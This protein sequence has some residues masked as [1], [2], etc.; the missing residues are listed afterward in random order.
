M[1]ARLDPTC[2]AARGIDEKHRE[3]TTL[4]GGAEGQLA[5]IVRNTQDRQILAHI[6]GCARCSSFRNA[7]CPE[8]AFDL[9]TQQHGWRCAR[10]NATWTEWL[11]WN[12]RARKAPGH[13]GRAAPTGHVGRGAPTGKVDGSSAARS[14]PVREG[15]PAARPVIPHRRSVSPPAAKLPTSPLSHAYAVLGVTSAATM[16]QVRKAFRE[17]A[18][19]Y[20]PDKVSHMA[21][22]FRVVAEQKMKEIN[23]AY[24]RIK[25][26]L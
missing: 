10:G 20:H 9:R 11:P 15:G 18:L 3:Q 26:A 22:E 1:D 19:Q 23:D 25:R 13:V 16:E 5:T 17:R 12:W 8:C 7:F 6:G 4:L 2:G 24:E 14:V 21:P